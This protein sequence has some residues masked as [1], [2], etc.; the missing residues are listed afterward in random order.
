MK[1][2]LVKR[3]REVKRQGAT[4]PSGSVRPG[5]AAWE[6]ALDHRPVKLGPNYLLLDLLQM[7][8]GV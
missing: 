2:L 6:P 5:K 3:G 1:N 7:Q 8:D 4:G